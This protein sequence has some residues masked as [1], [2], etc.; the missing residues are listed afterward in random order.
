MTSETSENSIF[1]WLYLILCCLILTK[2]WIQLTLK[3]TS[4]YHPEVETFTINSPSRPL[5][6]PAIRRSY[7]VK[8]LISAVLVAHLVTCFVVVVVVVVTYD[9]NCLASRCWSPT[10]QGSRR[11]IKD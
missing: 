11:E 5:N 3:M 2:C 6:H 10:T 8:L 4:A 9:S 1:V 7:S